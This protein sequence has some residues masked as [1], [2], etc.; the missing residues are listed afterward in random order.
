MLT[1]VTRLYTEP[2]ISPD[3]PMPRDIAKQWYVWFRFFDANKN[4]WIQFR[5]KKGINR[6][7]SFRERM[8]EANALR[9]I[10]REELRRGWN[11]ISVA[12]QPIKIYSLNEGIDYVLKIKEATL[13]KK[14][15]YA[16][17]YITNLF[18]EWLRAKNM[19]Q[20]RMKSFIGADAQQYMDW[21]LIHKKYSGRTYNDH[22]IVLRTFFNCFIERDWIVKNPFR[23]VKR[24][25]QTVGRNLAYTESERQ[26]LTDHLK[27]NDIRMYYF[28]Q[29]IYHCFI[30]RTE[31]TCIQVKHVDLINLTIVIPGQ[32]SKNN[33]QESVVIPKGLESIVKEMELGKYN[34][35]D[36]IFGRHM[37]TGP[38][39]YKNANWISTRHNDVVKA[40][41]INPEKGLYSHKHTGV[42]NYYYA[43]GKDL[44]SIQ[45]QCRHRDITTTM[46][47]MKSLG[48]IDNSTFKNA[49]VA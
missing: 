31:L 25:T 40:L 48:L 36:Y 37:N 28:T 20:A 32:D 19:H 24:K 8:K 47:Y 27:T 15:K 46:I 17:R 7:T 14:T 10:L 41:K 45:R 21:L 2:K 1:T 49:L 11:P 29:F 30:R 9:L 3:K 23:A 39:Q 42:C 26:R 16:Y 35:D 34:P 4:E 43:T 13:R 38:V 6:Y 12:D 22:L 33:F 18:I 5:Y 44:Y